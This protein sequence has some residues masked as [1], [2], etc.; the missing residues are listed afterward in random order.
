MSLALIKF[1][2]ERFLADAEPAVLCITGA[3]GV[4]KTFAW[5]RYL[6][7]AQTRKAIGLKDYAY[8]SL[9]GNNSLDE[10]KYAIFENTI[11][12]T[13][14]GIEPSLETLRTNALAVTKRITK[15]S[16]GIFQQLP[17]V[18]GHVGGLGPI[19]YLAVSRTIICI[20]D[21]ERRGK[22]LDLRDVLGLVTQLKEQKHC[23]VCLIL[24][25]EAL[26]ESQ[27]EFR[28]YFEKVVDTQLAFA[29]SPEEATGIA[30]DP[31]QPNTKRLTHCCVILGIANI[32][33]IKKIERAV[34]Q[35][36]PFLNSF[37]AMVTDQAIRSLVLFAWSLYEPQRA[38]TPEFLGD[39]F[40]FIVPEKRDQ[41]GPRE[42]AWNAL[43][44][45]YG[46]LAMDEFDS[47]LLV[48]LKNGYFDEAVIR[49]HATALDRT[50]HDAEAGDSIKEAWK[51]Y[52]DSFDDDQ[53]QTLDAIN[54]AF[55]ATI[56]HVDVLKLSQTVAFFK[57]LGRPE[58]AA[59]MLE[60]YIEAHRDNLAVFDI[61]NYPF[62]N[63]I[64]D[65]DVIRAFQEQHSA[66]ATQADAAAILRSM[67]E[68]RGWHP[69]DLAILANVSVHE[70]WRIFKGHRGDALHGIIN[71]CLQFRG[72]AD[73]QGIIAERA[74]AALE[75]IGRES[76]MNALRVSKYGVRVG[77]ANEV[78]TATQPKDLEAGSE[79]GE[80]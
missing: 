67:A 79:D 20:D 58:Q 74:R 32:R 26:N 54:K 68:R 17:V 60:A 57:E 62:R 13:G 55:F 14:I 6:K 43:L 42:A 35:V 77:G 47:A 3:W 24:N 44:D 16:L 39:R 30:I 28:T 31:K 69:D 33:L 5:N 7:E 73:N 56:R 53:E 25:D 48:G 71:I 34:Q 23:K 18:K 50:L 65:P 80:P 59:E 8:V 36:T 46:F 29:P 9:F 2:I 37:H 49:Q 63:R 76:P 38:P 51:G 21:I 41:I 52:H 10:L 19:W 75:L 66:V 12:A 64:T 15:K 70:Y 1:E 40:S 4:G 72:Q 45:A 78:E 11:A 61:E 27:H 22:N